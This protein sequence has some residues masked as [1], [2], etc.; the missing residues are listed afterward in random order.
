[1]LNLPNIITLVRIVCAPIMWWLI[2]AGEREWFAWVLTL[3]FTTDLVDGQL[4]RRLKKETRIGSILDS[5]GDT[6]TVLTGLVGSWM[7][8][9]AHFLAHWELLAIVISLHLIQLLLCLWRYGRPSSFHTYSAKAGALVIGCFLIYTMMFRFSDL[10][11]YVTMVFLVLD[12]LEESILV[13][14][15]PEWKNDVKGVYWVLK[16]RSKTA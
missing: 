2:W 1:M 10:F 12:A 15:I 4:A 5:Y 6:L 9:Q 3:A 8:E 16:S 11:F 14:L 7:F 13:F